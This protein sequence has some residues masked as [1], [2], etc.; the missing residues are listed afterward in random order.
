MNKIKGQKHLLQKTPFSHNYDENNVIVVRPQ[1]IFLSNFFLFL[2]PRYNEKEVLFIRFS[3]DILPKA[4]FSF[5]HSQFTWEAGQ[6]V[7]GSRVTI[8]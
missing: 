4:L 8:P 3:L 6:R 7:R 1:N 2:K 5:P